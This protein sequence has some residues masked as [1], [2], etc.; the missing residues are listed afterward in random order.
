MPGFTL[1]YIPPSCKKVDL[2]W[3]KCG[4]AN[5]RFDKPNGL[6][7]LQRTNGEVIKGKF[8]NGQPHGKM[9]IKMDDKGHKIEGQFRFVN[10]LLSP[11]IYLQ[12]W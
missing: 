12:L 5:F 6:G 9:E 4:H 1:G 8:R 7:V 3:N 11:M 10:V 2:I